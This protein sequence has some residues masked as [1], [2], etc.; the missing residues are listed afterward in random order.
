MSKASELIDKTKSQ[1]DPFLRVANNRFYSW[2]L[3]IN[4]WRREHISERQFTYV[5]AVIVGVLSGIIAL[6]MKNSVHVIEHILTGGFFQEYNYVLYI[7]Y[8]IVGIFLANGLLEK[9]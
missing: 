4:D 2:V 6:I 3:W 7:F 5:L 8:P 9:L 1:V